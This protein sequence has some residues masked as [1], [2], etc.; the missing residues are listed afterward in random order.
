[1]YSLVIIRLSLTTLQLENTEDFG[2]R[3]KQYILDELTKKNATDEHFNSFNNLAST[4]KKII[5]INGI[6]SYHL[7]YIIKH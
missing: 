5:Q 1:M 7:F 4:D 2:I 3:T 6:S